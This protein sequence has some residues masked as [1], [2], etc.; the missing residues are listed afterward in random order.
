[1]PID[2]LTMEPPALYRTALPLRP[3]VEQVLDADE[4]NAR[5]HQWI[6][7]FDKASQHGRRIFGCQM[8]WGDKCLILRID[9]EAVR[10]HELAH[11]AGWPKDHPG[12]IWPKYARER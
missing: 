4:V 8:M 1:M 7:L 10:A 12:G 11:C 9:S 6:E 5:C 2:V 3:V